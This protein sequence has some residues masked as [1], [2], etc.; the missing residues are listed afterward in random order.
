MPARPALPGQRP[1]SHS[2]SPAEPQ[3]PAP[4]NSLGKH[5]G[6]VG[7]LQG[8]P[9]V[10]PVAPTP[11]ARPQPVPWGWSRGSGGNPGGRQTPGPP[12]PGALGQTWW[13][14]P[15][16]PR[17]VPGRVPRPHRTAGLGCLN[18]GRGGRR[19]VG[20]A[21]TEPSSQHPAPSTLT[22][23]CPQTAPPGSRGPRAGRGRSRPAWHRGGSPRQSRRRA[24][25]SRCR[26]AGPS[27]RPPAG[28]PGARA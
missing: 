5:T 18:G 28:A 3:P 2:A 12:A 15:G 1:A 11:Q 4:W 9:H 7:G 22:H 6:P 14:E 25:R 19:P 26:T 20:P 13:V 17:R 10:C 21:Q 23:L 16:A 27:A 24:P 8:A